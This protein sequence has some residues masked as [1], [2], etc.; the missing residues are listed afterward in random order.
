MMVPID[1][2][3][4]FPMNVVYSQLMHRYLNIECRSLLVTE[5]ISGSSGHLSI[6]KLRLP[7]SGL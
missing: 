2:N 3:V 7:I 1:G 4:K 6:N 5:V